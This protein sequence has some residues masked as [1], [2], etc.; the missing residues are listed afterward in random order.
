[1]LCNGSVSGGRVCAKKDGPCPVGSS[2]GGVS[3]VGAYDMAGN[4]SEWVADLYHPDYY[5]TSPR[6]NPKG[7]SGH[8]LTLDICNSQGCGSK[9]GGDWTSDARELTTTHRAQH[10]LVV[11]SYRAGF[12]CAKSR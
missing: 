11:R 3:P 9:R 8:P 1:M 10:G 2:P 6:R 4:V 5:R 7:Y 12:R